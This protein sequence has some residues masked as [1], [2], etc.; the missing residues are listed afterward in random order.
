[1]GWMCI[2]LLI[3]DFCGGVVQDIHERCVV[4]LVGLQNV[5]KAEL[6]LRQI[7][8]NCSASQA[9]H[10]ATRSDLDTGPAA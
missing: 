9:K 1:M 8:N 2:F 5:Q 4:E 6:R 10:A 3:N 7:G